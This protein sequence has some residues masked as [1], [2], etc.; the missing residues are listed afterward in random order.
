M[1]YID[2]EKVEKR[3]NG[4]NRTT[5]L[6]NH[7]N[8][9]LKRKLQV[10]GNIGKGHNQPEMREKVRK[11]FL[12]KNK[13]TFQSYKPQGSSSCKIP[14]TIFKIKGEIWTKGLGNW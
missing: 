13:K 4:R 7:S 14:W 8:T 1:C 9:L 2:Y 12:K 6:E 11:K 5:K 3:N 10:I